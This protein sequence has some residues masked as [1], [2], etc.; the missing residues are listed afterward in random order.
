MHLVFWIA[1]LME[2]L[3]AQ[4]MITGSKQSGVQTSLTLIEER[5]TV[6]EQDIIQDIALQQFQL[7]T[8]FTDQTIQ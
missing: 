6:K 1:N 3:I 5:E 7:Q 2:E 8:A 4:E